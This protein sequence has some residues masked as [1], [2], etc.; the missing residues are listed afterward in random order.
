MKLRNIILFLLILSGPATGQN[1]TSQINRIKSDSSYKYGEG[2]GRT[3]DE[4]D[5]EAL[6]NLVRNIS[7]SVSS[8]FSQE[9][10]HNAVND[11]SYSSE[12][13]ESRLKTYSFATLRNVGQ[14][15]L[16]E[17]NPA[18]V[19]RYIKQ[20]EIDKSF[21]ERKERVLSFIEDANKAIKMAQVGD[22][23]KYYYWA[24]VLLNTVPDG[25]KL[26]AE[27][28]GESVTVFTWCY[29]RISN[30]I[31]D[32]TVEVS[33]IK[34][35]PS[36]N[37]VIFDVRYK[38][39]PVAN[40]DF[41]YWMGQRYST[42]Y[43]VKDGRG[44]ADLEHIENGEQIKLKMEYQY[45]NIANNL[46]SE[47]R[48]CFGANTPSMPLNVIQKIVPIN[49]SKQPKDNK[50]TK[51]NKSK[52]ETSTFPTAATSQ[53]DEWRISAYARNQFEEYKSVSLAMPDDE[54]YY[55][56]KMRL[57][58]RAI[59]N[60]EYESIIPLFTPDG[61]S[62]FEKLVKYGNATIVSEPKYIC[63][64]FKNGV[65]CRSIPL[66]FKFKQNRTFIEDVIFRFDADGL[67]DSIA[68]SLNDSIEAL[69]LD[70]GFGWDN[71]SRLLMM[72][73]MEDYQTAYSLK[74]LDYIENVFADDAVIIV[75]KMLKIK[76]TKQ[77]DA[78]RIPNLLSDEEVEY[79]RYTKAEFIKR[80][81]NNFASKEYINIQF[82][83][84][85]IAKMTKVGEIY[86][87]H[88]KQY[89]YSNNYS[90]TGYLTLLIDM[91]DSENPLIHMRVWNPKK[92]PNF[93]AIK[94]LKEGGNLL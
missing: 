77:I 29:D 63:I 45:A 40:M 11:N 60:K 87:V 57:I 42:T 50:P 79:R 81:R 28:D 93:T 65:I 16:S 4:A 26:R 27:V 44:T 89:Y 24:M 48:G 35:F 75:G 1:L 58:E 43:S 8:S 88:I 86:A 72:T 32:I 59:R 84:I 46:D 18:K 54:S 47:L 74:R 22:A 14:I 68:F 5:R 38:N 12:N 51:S 31:K 52:K 94:F 13:I 7:V 20:E 6:E 62:M 34:S 80:L 64:N 37:T 41:Q 33:D 53:L 10:T 36:Y 25:A 56:S 69:L 90:D 82:E 91:R 15:I 70:A 23:I 19:F 76:K 17:E 66:Q 67:V 49:T 73:F 83:D 39:M 30:I 85:D 61:Y 55:I 78:P 21:E 92:D 3:L 71:D 9:E 2:T